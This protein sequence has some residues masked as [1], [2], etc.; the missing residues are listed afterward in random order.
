MTRCQAEAEATVAV[1]VAVVVTEDMVVAAEGK[2]VKAMD[3]QVTR[4]CVVH[5]E[6]T[7][8]IMAPG[9][10]QTQCAHPGR[11]SASM[12]EPSMAMTWQMSSR[13]RESWFWQN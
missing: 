11:R 3:P 10:W 13:T 2:V 8:S 5:L 1:D 7:S 4:A 6:A 12:L 9:M